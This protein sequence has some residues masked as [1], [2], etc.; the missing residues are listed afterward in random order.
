[1]NIIDGHFIENATLV[2]N[3]TLQKEVYSDF[4]GHD[5]VIQIL[6]DEYSEGIKL[7]ETSI[8]SIN[9]FLNLDKSNLDWIKSELWKNCNHSFEFASYGVIPPT[10]K[11]GQSEYDY[12]KDLFKIYNQHDAFIKSKAEYITI[13]ND[14][15]LQSLFMIDY[16]TPWDS[17]H[18]LSFIFINGEK[19]AV[20]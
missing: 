3:T 16:K 9:D 13:F 15:E 14:S 10:L 20:E 5:I 7:S 12:N 11:E 8:R 19:H 18:G 2:N 4:L 17:E 1:M 6:F